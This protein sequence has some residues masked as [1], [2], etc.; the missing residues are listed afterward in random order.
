VY[1]ELEVNDPLAKIDAVERRADKRGKVKT[2]R[3]TVQVGACTKKR[4]CRLTPR[5]EPRALF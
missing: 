3:N 2:G 1:V 4:G 5:V